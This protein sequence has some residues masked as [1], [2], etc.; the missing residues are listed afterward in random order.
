MRG[1]GRFAL[2]ALLACSLVPIPAGTAAADE[3]AGSADGS[4]DAALAPGTY[5]EHE[6]I[7]Y[8][9]DGGAQAFS[10]NDDLLGKRREPDEHR[11]RERPSRRERRCG[12]GRSRRCGSIALVE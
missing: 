2:G 5:V 8:V 1:F 7:A 11:R 9:I 4:A 3:T 6:A 10:L 12:G